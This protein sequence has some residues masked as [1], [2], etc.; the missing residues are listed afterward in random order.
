VAKKKTK[1][2]NKLKRLKKRA[3]KL[4]AVKRKLEKRVRKLARKLGAS[5]QRA[6]ELG[7]ALNR[8]APIVGTTS[9]TAAEIGADEGGGVAATHRAAWKQ[10]S[11]LRDR[12]EI[13]LGTGATK[14]RARQLA[15][16]DLK[17]EYGATS[18]F[19]EEELT[20]ILS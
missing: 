12:Y 9:V 7:A 14:D 16:D 1:D 2:R 20:A 17:T 18:G 4:T 11:Y 10:H 8:S 15:N 19:S 13:H 3:R 5:E 6:A